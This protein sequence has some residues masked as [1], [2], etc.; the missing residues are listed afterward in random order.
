MSADVWAS[1]RRLARLK[2][3]QIGFEPERSSTGDS[4]VRWAPLVVPSVFSVGFRG[5]RRLFGFERESRAWGRR[6]AEEPTLLLAMPR[7]K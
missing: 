4:D 1:R 3:S 2:L 7:G 5:R 6:T